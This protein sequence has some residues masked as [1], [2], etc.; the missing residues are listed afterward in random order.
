MNDIANAE[1]LRFAVRLV[2]L[3]PAAGYW[4]AVR[5]DE[6]SAQAWPCYIS[7]TGGHS[8]KRRIFDWNGDTRS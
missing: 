2:Q 3:L 8:F 5:H 6:V 1:C 7:V 4:D